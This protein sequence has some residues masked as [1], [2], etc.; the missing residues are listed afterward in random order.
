MKKKI[1][2][3][4]TATD[5]S[6]AKMI[7]YYTKKPY[8]HSSISFDR[9]LNEMYSMSRK[10]PR[11]PFYG[12]FK[13]ELIND[14]L[15]KYYPNTPARLLEIEVTNEQYIQ[16][17]NFVENIK[18]K[19]ITYNIKGLIYLT[20]NK[21]YKNINKYFCSEFIADLLE[22]SLIYDFNRPHNL[23]TPCDFLKIPNIKVVYEGPLYKINDGVIP[24]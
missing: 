8:S 15:F 20:L 5:T 14:G 24:A 12:V 19:N 23:I 10:Y 11:N 7:R 1:Y 16:A 6:F 4:L 18:D 21:E 22:N 9:E 17:Y 13:R 3:L 2:I